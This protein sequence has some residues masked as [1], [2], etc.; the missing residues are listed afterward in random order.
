MAG[1]G[2]KA[3][4]AA[5][6]AVAAGVRLPARTQGGRGTASGSGSPQE[7]AGP[8]RGEAERPDATAARAGRG[9]LPGAAPPTGAGRDGS[10]RRE[11]AVEKAAIGFT[12]ASPADWS[13]HG[14]A[15][16]AWEGRPQPALGLSRRPPRY[17]APPLPPDFAS[18]LR[19]LGFSASFA[20]PYPESPACAVVWLPAVTHSF[21]RLPAPPFGRCSLGSSG[22]SRLMERFP[23]VC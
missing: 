15:L 2:I 4:V 19:F 16:L 9:S 8:G 3:A 14:A 7:G 10:A 23:C 22:A 13:T 18:R 21:P 11:A 20:H 1:W 6:V 5:E 17:P 12:F